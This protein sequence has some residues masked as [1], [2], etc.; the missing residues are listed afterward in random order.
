MVHLRQQVTVYQDLSPL[1]HGDFTVTFLNEEYRMTNRGLE[2]TIRVSVWGRNDV[3]M[4]ESLVT[5]LSVLPKRQ[6]GKK[7]PPTKTES[8]AE[9]N[10]E[11]PNGGVGGAMDSESA[12]RSSGTLLSWVRAPPQKTQVTVYKQQDIEANAQVG[13][14]FACATQDYQP[15][16]VSKWTAKLMGFKSSIA[17]GLW[18]MAVTVDRIMA[19]DR[20]EQSKPD[21]P[22]SS[23]TKR[24]Q[25][26]STRAP[27]ELQCSPRGIGGTVDSKFALRSA[28]ISLVVASRPATSAL[29]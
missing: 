2:N 29:A 1:L 10:D 11:D 15:Q 5:G 23:T 12:L 26:Q 25:D 9:E 3:I 21:K 18:S 19:S 22:S 24:Y 4:W 13:Y 6:M 16:H 7:P 27:V 14:I 28:G 20:P 8:L 17:H